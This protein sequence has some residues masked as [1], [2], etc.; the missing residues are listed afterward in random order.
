M[1]LRACT[2]TTLTPEGS[3][4]ECCGEVTNKDTTGNTHLRSQRR[5]VEQKEIGPGLR[6]LGGLYNH[7]KLSF[8]IMSYKNQN[9]TTLK[10][11]RDFS[12]AFFFRQENQHSKNVTNQSSNCNTQ[13]IYRRDRRELNPQKPI[14]L[15]CHSQV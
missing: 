7:Q 11:Y 12:P 4:E 3:W 1:Q 14:L 5:C 10:N 2:S 13:L 15:E 9:I 6:L 8:P